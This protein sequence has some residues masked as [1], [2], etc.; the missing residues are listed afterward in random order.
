MKRSE[1]HAAFFTEP[2]FEATL[3]V[4]GDK[5][6]VRIWYRAMVEKMA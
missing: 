5:T 4:I 2:P 1:N 3:N 6:D